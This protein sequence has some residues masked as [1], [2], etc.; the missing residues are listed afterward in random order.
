MCL[1]VFLIKLF[2]IPWISYGIHGFLERERGLF[3]KL[4]KNENIQNNWTFSRK[5]KNYEPR[6]LYL[7]N[8]FGGDGFV[9]K[10]YQ[11]HT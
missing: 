6:A 9:P 3:L 7:E 8:I 5:N 2:R 4:E 11:T 10:P 1:H